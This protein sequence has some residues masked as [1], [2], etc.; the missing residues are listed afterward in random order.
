MRVWASRWM[1]VGECKCLE[2]QVEKRR[3]FEITSINSKQAEVRYEGKG[4]SEGE[5]V[6]MQGGKSKLGFS[7]EELSELGEG[8]HTF[9]ECH[10]LGPHG[11]IHRG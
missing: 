11:A 4:F 7:F 9:C 1:K 3:S 8:H 10:M 5:I 2:N 6:D